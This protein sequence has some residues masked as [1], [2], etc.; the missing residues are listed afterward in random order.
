MKKIN[1]LLVLFMAII[2]CNCQEK[3]I[4]ISKDTDLDSLFEEEIINQGIVGAAAAYSINGET[5]WETVGGYS[6]EKTKQSF[7]KNTKVRMASIA[8]SMTAIAIMQLVEKGLLDL[9]APIQNYVPNYP[10]QTKTQ[11]T[12][13]HLLSHTSGIDGYKNTKEAETQIN[14]P[15]LDD[16]ITIF[17]NRPLLFEPGTGYNYTTYGYTLLGLILENIS[18]L[19]YE[20]Y[21][22]KN[23]WDIAE[24]NNTGIDVYGKDEGNSSKLYSKRRNGKTIEGTENNLSNRVPGGG[25]YTTIGDMMK[26]GNS[27]IENTLI[28]RETLDLMRQRHSVNTESKYGFGWFLYT[29][30]PNEGRLI[31]HGGAQMGCSSQLFIVPD[32]G[33]VS[34]VL[35]NTSRTEVTGFAAKLAKLALK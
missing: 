22:R 33:V 1:C 15:T 32:E 20:D 23:I 8:K 12:T 5:I 3:K 25:F 7:Q 4:E 26:F 14:Y 27:V 24:M 19:T 34:V 2:H 9:D 18:G 11:I 16:A 17:K 29:P 35:A 6:D 13:R 31:G 10:K 21:M 28:K 30:A